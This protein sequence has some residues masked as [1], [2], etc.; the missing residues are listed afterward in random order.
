MV[1][2]VVAEA[3]DASKAAATTHT[4]LLGRHTDR[5]KPTEQRIKEAGFLVDRCGGFI[6]RPIHRS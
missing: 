6:C 5:M 4:M 1:T 2:G 3:V